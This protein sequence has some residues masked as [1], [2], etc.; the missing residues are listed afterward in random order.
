LCKVLYEIYRRK[1]PGG[2]WSTGPWRELVRNSEYE[3]QLVTNHAA[4][5]VRKLRMEEL[6]GCGSENVGRH[7]CGQR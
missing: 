1:R 3:L 4:T 5:T 2:N 6:T 7:A